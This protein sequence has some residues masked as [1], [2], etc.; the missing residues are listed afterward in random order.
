M[1]T[2]EAL[3]R[4]GTEILT[5]KGFHSTGI[6]EVLKHVGVPKGS[7]YHYFS[8]KDEFGLAIIDNY[9]AYFARKLDRLL[10]NGSRT[11]LARIADFVADAKAGMARHRFRRGCLIGNMGQELGALHEGF[12]E[13]LKSVF[14]D[15][16]DRMAGCLEAARAAGEIAPDAECRRLAAFFWIGWEGAVLQ[17]KLVRS[18]RP[19]DLFAENFFAGLPRGT[20]NAV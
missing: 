11:P 7:F 17:A 20:S 15:W 12:R 5:E 3:I 16:Q 13:R 14:E 6:D 10:R 9:A 19:L 4:Y 1:E 18:T 2:R 8:S